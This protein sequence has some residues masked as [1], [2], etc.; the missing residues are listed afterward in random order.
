MNFPVLDCPEKLRLQVQGEL[1]DFVQENRTAVGEDKF[2]P[3]LNAPGSGVGFS[4]MA[5]EVALDH[6]A[7]DGGDIADDEGFVV[8]RTVAL[9]E[10]C[11]D[12]LAGAV[13]P[14]E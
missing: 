4:P 13:F 10:M 6:W 7:R 12:F 8:A 11:D 5:K 1:T 2:S 9:D 14:R 3:A